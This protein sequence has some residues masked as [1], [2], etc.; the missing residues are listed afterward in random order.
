M[1]VGLLDM[2]CVAVGLLDMFSM[3]VAESTARGLRARRPSF[4]A[5]V[6]WLVSSFSMTT[7][8]LWG[9]SPKPQALR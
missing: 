7:S 6:S 5:Y 2:F 4:S 1:A 9:L 3:G 8:T